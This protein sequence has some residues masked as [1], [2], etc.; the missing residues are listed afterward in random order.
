[1]M[2]LMIFIA[3]PCSNACMIFIATPCSNACVFAIACACPVAASF[4]RA[5]SDSESSSALLATAAVLR[6]AQ[7]F[8]NKD[9]APISYWL[10][11]QTLFCAYCALIFLYIEFICPYFQILLILILSNIR[12]CG[13]M[14]VRIY[15][16]IR[17]LI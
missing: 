11:H 12:T 6:R 10:I 16:K 2:A 15:G 9:T 13:C 3:T 8:S 1:M 4:G 17:V 5:A 7:L 14:N